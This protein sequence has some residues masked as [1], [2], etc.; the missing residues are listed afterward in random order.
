[1]ILDVYRFYIALGV[2]V[3]VECAIIAE[4]TDDARG[5]QHAALVIGAANAILLA[6]AWLMVRM[7]EV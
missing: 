7:S 3:L 6:V 2:F 4:A 5:R 1:M